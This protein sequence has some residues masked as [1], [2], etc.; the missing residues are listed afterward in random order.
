M[1]GSKI[2]VNPVKGDVSDSELNARG[3]DFRHPPEI[4]E[5][6]PLD[7]ILLKV[8]LKP[9]EFMITCKKSGPYLK[10]SLRY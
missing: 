2:S 8:I 5:G 7:P 3:G 10:N 6:K 1:S 9:I 4:N